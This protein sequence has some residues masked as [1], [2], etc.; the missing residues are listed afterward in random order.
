MTG[1]KWNLVE[2][3]NPACGMLWLDPA[4]A[5]EDLPRLYSHYYTHEGEPAHRR[6]RLNRFFRRAESAYLAEKYGYGE[7]RGT[8]LTRLRAALMYAR[9]SR[10][11]ALDFDVFYLRARAGARLLE[12]GC[13]SGA[14]LLRMQ[15]RG[16]QVEGVDF[17]PLAV[18]Q[19]RGLGLRVGMGDILKMS[20]PA[21]IYD[22]VIM[23]HVIEHVPDARSL[24]RECWRLLRPRGRL[25]IVTPN[26]KSMSHRLFGRYW[27]GLE[28][29]RHL[30]LF[31]TAPLE[32]LCR[33]AGLEIETNRSTGRDARGMFMASTQLMLAGRSWATPFV[34]GA[35]MRGA[36]LWELLVSVLLPLVPGLGDEIVCIARKPRS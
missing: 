11:A 33:E 34:S 7:G 21:S 8:W 26:V 4:P 31:A 35:V 2:C 24:L 23:S 19:A 25:V 20:L 6:S 29:P 36:R 1:G 5:A 30:Q 32:R 13:G 10:R 9:P 14:M 27:R 3:A 17:D 12:I 28:P 18:A 22:V 16:W 15:Q